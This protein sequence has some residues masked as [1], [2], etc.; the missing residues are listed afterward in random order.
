[1]QYMDH[2]TTKHKTKKTENAKG[3]IDPKGLMANDQL[4]LLIMLMTLISRF[5]STFHV[6]L[7]CFAL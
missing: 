2:N 4:Y 6:W 7:Y 1:M 3:L 5:M